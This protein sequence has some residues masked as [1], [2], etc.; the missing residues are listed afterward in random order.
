MVQ[1]SMSMSMSMGM[2]SMG[3]AGVPSAPVGFVQPDSL[4]EAP[5]PYANGLH[6]LPAKVTFQDLVDKGRVKQLRFADRCWDAP[7]MAQAVLGEF[8]QYDWLNPKYGIDPGDWRHENVA[9]EIKE[10]VNLGTMAR[11]QFRDEILAQAEDATTFWANLLMMYPASCPATF[12][13]HG[14]RQGG[15]YD[16]SYVLQ[17]RLSA[18]AAGAGLS[19]PDAA[20]DE[21]AARLLPQRSCAAVK[22]DV[23]VAGAGWCA[24]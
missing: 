8:S 17:A 15:R 16:D 14:D 22:S 19:S 23:R 11:G 1:F 2:G 18:P 3:P 7:H 9:K 6:P 13:P 12:Y 5:T 24:P 10:L 20:A 4:S 21:P